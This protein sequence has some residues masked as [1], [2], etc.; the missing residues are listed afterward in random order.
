M[1]SFK[2]CI[3]MLGEAVLLP[4]LLGIALPA[5]V[6][7]QAQPPSSTKPAT[8]PTAA[9]SPAKDNS[10]AQPAVDPETAKANQRIVD[11]LRAQFGVPPNIQLN[12]VKRTASPI[13]GLE[14]ALVE[15]LDGPNKRTQEILVTKDNKYAILGR[16][17]NLE[18]N[19][20]AENMKKIKLVDVPTRGN[21]D[22][23]VTLVEY[24][25]FQ[26]PFCGQAY[27]TIENDVVKQYG[28][29]IRIVYKNF[30]LPNHPWAENAAIAGLC[31]FDQG[32]DAF[33]TFYHAFFDNQST[34]TT[35]NIKD[36][37]MSFAA[38]AKLDTKKFEDCYDKKLTLPQIKAD[39]AEAQSLGI[40]G[41]PLFIVNGH[42]ISGVQPFSA[43][44]KVI[45][46]ELHK[47]SN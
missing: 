2:R 18:E 4:L 24:S 30:P 29:K 13:P 17:F 26:C 22:A 27:K 43:F 23:K 45:D 9:P 21:K 36:K 5:G 10:T 32:N 46:E 25:D 1:K 39:M 31:A 28:D 37:A 12:V 15:A 20:F 6:L 16:L 42:S 14:V 8:P 35:D 47:S 11:N 44:Q 33:W 7:A 41:T 19:P 40:T 34:I 38:S 3:S